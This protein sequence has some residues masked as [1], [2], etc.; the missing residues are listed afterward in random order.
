MKKVFNY[1]FKNWSTTDCI[2]AGISILF[3]IALTIITKFSP[4]ASV[5]GVCLVL[6][7]I[8]L[9][10]NTLLGYILTLASL[11][12][13]GYFVNSHLGAGDMFVLFLV[14][15]PLI[16]YSG[17]NLILKKNKQPEKFALWD[18]ITLVATI[19]VA[20][21]PTILLLKHLGSTLIL[22]QTISLMVAIIIAFLAMKGIAWRK[23][24]YI[25]IT[26]LQLFNYITLIAELD[27]D[28]VVLVF[29]V[30]IIVIVQISYFVIFLIDLIK[31]L[32]KNKKET[33]QPTKAVEE[34]D[35]EAKQPKKVG[36]TKQKQNPKTSPKTN[37]DKNINKS[38][39]TNKKPDLD[40]NKASNDKKQPTKSKTTKKPTTQKKK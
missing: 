8:Y 21:Y 25:I 32:I 40:E 38:S 28:I 23:Y 29:N 5:T 35:K 4:F 31:K 9:P 20:V 11:G 30:A 6:S 1:V 18:Y 34:Q 37:E 19:G 24:L 22:T 7:A 14:I 16:I 33:N 13:Y 39:K 12:M 36:E 26:C 2:I 15:V 17:V 3:T 27:L 10:K